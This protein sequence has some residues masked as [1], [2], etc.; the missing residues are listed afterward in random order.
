MDAHT[1]VKFKWN[2]KISPQDLKEVQ[3]LHSLKHVLPWAEGV[4]FNAPDLAENE[5]ARGLYLIQRLL[6][7]PQ[8]E[9]VLALLDSM[10]ALIKTCSAI[11][12]SLCHPNAEYS[13]MQVVLALQSVVI[14][15]DH[16]LMGMAVN[17]LGTI[18]Y[19]PNG[20]FVTSAA[21]SHD[22]LNKKY[23][24]VKDDYAV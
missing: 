7:D 19:F 21:D 22:I 10:S 4:E 24:L 13:F 5:F 20:K 17:G 2:K 18:R 8:N 16:K 9:E 23:R 1:W 12:L 15:P 11:K 3:N 14:N 6:D